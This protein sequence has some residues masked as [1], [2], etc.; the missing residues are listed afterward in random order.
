MIDKSD[1]DN[2]KTTIGI[3][4]LTEWGLF[5]GDYENFKERLSTL[6]ATLNYTYTD[7]ETHGFATTAG[8]S[9]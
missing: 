5:S 1:Y 6:K 4:A 8:M 3:S 7:Q 2:A 9:Q